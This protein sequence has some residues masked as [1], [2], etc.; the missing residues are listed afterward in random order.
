MLMKGGH[1][2]PNNVRSDRRFGV[3]LRR[4]R[5]SQGMS[6]TTVGKLA[7]CSHV[8]LLQIEQGSSRAPSVTS[9]IAQVLEGV[10]G[11][12]VSVYEHF[13]W[14]VS[15]LDPL[16]VRLGAQV[17]LNAMTAPFASAPA[18][19]TGLS[20]LY[21]W[22]PERLSSLLDHTWSDEQ[23]GA[24]NLDSGTA[25]ATGAALTKDW[26]RQLLIDFLLET[27][28]AWTFDFNEP[29]DGLCALRLHLVSPTA[30]G[31]PEVVV[32]TIPHLTPSG[33]LR[34]RK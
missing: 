16:S 19:S 13:L 23:S 20:E 18:L 4:W 5:L 2:M 25:I 27:T 1:V 17:V 30:D 6:L 15:A 22:A 33:V 34:S 9:D 12:Q 31:K 26:P 10:T 21:R 7:K 8:Y 29:I 11:L 24:W 28:T 32:P 14:D 3:Q